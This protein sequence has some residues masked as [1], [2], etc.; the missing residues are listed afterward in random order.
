MKEQVVQRILDKKI[1]AI[2]RGYSIEECINLARALYKGGVE[3]MECTFSQTD[4]EERKLTV[5]TIKALKKELGDVMEFGAGTV[6]SVEMVKMAK[7]AGATFIVSPDTNKEVIKATCDADMVSIPGGLTP[8]EMKQAWDAGA[9]FVKVFPAG[10]VGPKYFKDVHAPLSQVRMLAVGSV[11]ADNLADYL[12]CGAVG[13]GV[14]SCLFTKD[15]IKAGE[16]DKITA[17]AKHV[18]SIVEN[19]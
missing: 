5:E 17:A 8:T 1:M 18:M 19:V 9:D 10:T 7:E 12:K 13:A 15:W 6:T 4:A 2:V 16:W 11:N 3:L 14:A